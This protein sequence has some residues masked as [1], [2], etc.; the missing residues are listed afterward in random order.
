MSAMPTDTLIHWFNTLEGLLSLIVVVL[1]VAAAAIVG[2]LVVLD[3]LDAYRLSN[4][5]LFS[6]S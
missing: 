4:K 5:R 2:T 1:I 6:S 3:L